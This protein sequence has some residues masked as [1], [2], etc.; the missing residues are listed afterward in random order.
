[1]VFCQNCGTKND[2]H[3]NF[4]LN[5]G[6]KLK[7]KLFTKS[8]F[9]YEPVYIIFL[10]RSNGHKIGDTYPNYFKYQ[11]ESDTD[12]LLKKTIQ[13]NH[14]KES[15]LNHC[16][17]RATV[18][19]LKES[20]KKHDLKVSGRKKELIER[21]QTNIS[22]E[23]IKADFTD[24]YYVLTSEGSR[25]VQENDHILYYHRSQN[26]HPVPLEKYHELL[27]DANR[28]DKNL[29]YDLALKL[30]NKYAINYREK[31][32]WGL[33]RNIMLS[34]ANV[35]QDK[36]EDLGALVNYLK[37]IN[38]DLSGLSNGNIYWPKNCFLAPGLIPNIAK[39]TKNL[40]LDED[41][42]KKK[43]YLC[44][45][46][47]NLPKTAFTKEESFNYLI[48]AMGGDLEGVDSI[49]KNKTSQMKSI[50]K[51]LNNL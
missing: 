51:P 44:A 6:T 47:L 11:Y 2:D 13:N 34:M 27:K 16:L 38:I 37:V 14:L 20:L 26:L 3:S 18:K 25:L 31:G 29:K 15:D 39:L 1:M 28:E 32:D 50:L 9:N 41:Y 10:E 7:N 42:L 46:E 12:L 24:S 40:D 22:E 19:E 23:T 17:E 33:Y 35:Y 30:L 5:C 48:Q 49:I 45:K 8:S 4:C 43:Y 36:K 21:L